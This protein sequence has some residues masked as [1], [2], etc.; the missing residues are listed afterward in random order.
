[1]NDVFSLEGKR[2]LVTGASK[3]IGES[4]AIALAARGADVLIAARDT[5]KLARVAQRIVSMGRS[6]AYVAAD[7]STAEGVEQVKAAAD[8]F[9]R[10]D[11]YV[12]NA[13]FTL[14]KTPMESEISDI[15]AL[16]N[17]NFKGALGITQAMARKMMVQGTGGVILFVTSINAQSALPSQALYSCTKASLESIMRSL[18]AELSPYGIRV[19]SLAPGAIRTDMNPHFTEE[20]LKEM[21]EKIPLGHVGEPEEIADVAVFLCSEASRY[22]TGSTVT[23]DG[24]YLLRR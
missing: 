6:C 12:N 24:G 13:A 4:I 14:Y 16:Y 9:G 23:V 5:E 10:I 2:A 15:D 22:M 20:K 3:G 7:V 19:N 17:T 1:M 21:G 11:C 8:A 18:A